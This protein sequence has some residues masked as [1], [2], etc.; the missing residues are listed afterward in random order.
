V[1]R[2]SL[3]LLDQAKAEQAA[4]GANR[5]NE[6][7]SGHDQEDDSLSAPP[8]LPADE[9]PAQRAARESA[10]AREARRSGGKSKAKG[11]RGRTAGKS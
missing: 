7:D 11:K 3:G 4:A 6:R 8:A 9:T 5:E 2:G 10:E 1:T